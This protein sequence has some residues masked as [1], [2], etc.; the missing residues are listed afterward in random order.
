MIFY[1]QRM[2]HGGLFILCIFSF[3]A[4][5]LFVCLGQWNFLQFIFEKIPFVEKDDE[6]RISEE[7][8]VEHV[9]K[10]LFRLQ[11]PV[12]CLILPQHLVV[13]AQ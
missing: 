4:G 11:H 13:V 3:W 6:R 12:R 10:E 1:L 9:A 7:D 2:F 5:V 8:I